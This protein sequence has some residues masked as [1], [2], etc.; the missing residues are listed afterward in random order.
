M[1][2]PRVP[3]T[4]G[5][6]VLL[7]VVTATAASSAPPASAATLTFTGRG[8]GHGIG[9]SQWGAKGLADKGLTGTQILTQFYS[10]TRL[11]QKA[12]PAQIRVGLLTGRTEVQANGDALFDFR[13]SGQKATAKPGE[14]WR[15][16]RSPAGGGKLDVLRPDNSKA[17]TASSPVSISSGAGARIK[18]PQT[19]YRYARGRIDVES[20][21]SDGTKLRAVLSVGFEEYLYGL[22]EVPSSWPTAAL[23]AQAVAGRTYALEKALRLGQ[24]RPTCNCAVYATTADQAYVG[25]EK[26]VGA[27]AANWKSAV[28]ATRG[29]VVTSGGKPIQAF[30]SSSSGGHTEHNENIWGGA[31]LGYLRGVCDPGDFAGGSNPHAN[32]SGSIDS[33]TL[34]QKLKAAGKDVG[35]VSKVEFLTPRGVSGRILG[36]K[37]ADHGGV[38]ITGSSGTARLSGSDFRSMAGLKSTLIGPHIGGAIRRRYDDLSCKPGIAK[39]NE[40]TWKYLNGTARGNAQDFANGRLFLTSDTGKVFWVY[41]SILKKYDALRG[42]GADFGMP[43]TDEIAVTGGRASHFEKGRIYWRSSTGAKEVHG[44]I[45]AKYVATGGPGVWGLPTSDETAVP[46]GRAS[47]F[48][49]ARI[50]WSGAT[51][52]HLMKGAILEKYLAAGG[53]ATSGLPTTD[54][55]AVP[56]GVSTV[57][58]RAR[59][60][61]SSKTGAHFLYG[62]I[63]A[64]Y[65]AIGGPGGFGLPMTDE[66]AV[67]NGRASYFQSGRIYYS[68][69]TGTHPVYGAILT[70]YLKKGGPDSALGLPKSDEYDVAGGRRSD[71]QGGS[72]T[73]NRS[74]NTTTVTTN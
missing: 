43:T 66:I 74:T 70:A 50:Y 36:V 39:N 31:P 24:N 4:I 48:D 33:G 47:Y 38:K 65:L 46:G 69:A 10:G 8:W 23:R 18:L 27:S 30:Y 29:L 40:Y 60:Y 55:T 1:R 21:E 5:R 19:G 3:K 17:F 11:E 49:R 61:W 37:N 62:G 25:Y 20:Y 32:W 71:F 12:A 7:V 22:G 35:T 16:V 28:D 58:Q 67:R 42:I 51:G 64:K 34:A 63:L 59:Y 14:T 73:W 54:E 9:M 72:I 56:G 53:P 52:A 2:L 45:L 68:G 6:A 13:G 26:E 44:G 15:V 57:T 41:G